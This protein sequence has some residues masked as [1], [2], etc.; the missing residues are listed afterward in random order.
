M[1]GLR[2]SGGVALFAAFANHKRYN[3]ERGL[4]REEKQIQ[5]K[6]NEKGAEKHCQSVGKAGNRRRAH[7]KHYQR[8]DRMRYVYFFDF[9]GGS[10]A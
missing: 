7:A 8:I 4:N 9:H 3:E 1:K 10:I 5:Q 6:R 2:L